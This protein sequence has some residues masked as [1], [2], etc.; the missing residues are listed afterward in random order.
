MTT[1]RIT[2][3]GLTAAMALMAAGCATTSS[4][5]PATALLQV[6]SPGDADM[7]CE[8][9]S[10]EIGRMDQM[11]GADMQ[12]AANAEARGSAAAAGTS[13]A[14]NAAAYSGALGRVPGLGFA[15]NAAGGHA[16]AQA[17]AEAE[18][19]EENV[20]RAELRRTSLMGIY[21]GRDC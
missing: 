13:A 10:A 6:N 11:M 1:T 4:S 17:Q 9:L 21:Q 18:R 14:I 20:R 5:E 8:Q 12:A 19:R 16:Q 2:A 7:S 3:F 15:A